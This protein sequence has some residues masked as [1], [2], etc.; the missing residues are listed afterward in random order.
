MGENWV[1]VDDDENKKKRKKELKNCVN[2]RNK[3][4]NSLENRSSV[5]FCA[6][7]NSFRSDFYHRRWL[8][9]WNVRNSTTLGKYEKFNFKVSQN[10]EL[11]NEKWTD[12]KAFPIVAPRAWLDWNKNKERKRKKRLKSFSWPNS[13]NFWILLMLISEETERN[14]AK[15]ESGVEMLSMIKWSRRKMG[16][17]VSGNGTKVLK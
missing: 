3:S 10:Q 5:R 15:F 6:T 1:Y 12:Q 11:C 8:L 2:C 13:S 7:V 9:S 14:E 17:N 4:R 16:M